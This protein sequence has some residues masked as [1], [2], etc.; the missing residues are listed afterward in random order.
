MT[1]ASSGAG[2]GGGRR[3]VAATGRLALWLWLVAPLVLGPVV[4]RAQECR[5][6][7]FLCLDESEC[8]PDSLRCDGTYDCPDLSDEL[9]CPLC[10]PGEWQCN[11]GT[12][13][14]GN[15]RC[16]FTRNC[17]YDDSDE[18]GC[19]GDC[20]PDQFRCGDGSCINGA[21]RCNGQQDCG[22]GSD[23]YNC[24][25]SCRFDEYR[26]RDGS[27]LPIHQR[28]DGDEQCS[29]GD[30]ELGCGICNR[31]QYQCRDGTCISFTKRCDRSPDCSDGSDEL[32][33]GSPDEAPCPS[34]DF[35]CYDLSCIP[36]SRMCDGRSDCPSG[37]DEQNCDCAANEFTCT[38]RM[39]IPDHLRCNYHQDCEDGSDEK[40]CP[41]EGCRQD[42]FTC[43][44]GECITNQYRCDGSYDCTDDSDELN[45]PST[46][47]PAPST[48]SPLEFEC[49]RGRCLSSSFRC[50]RVFD[51][52]DMSDEQGCEGQCL[53][54]QFRCNDSSCIPESRRCDNYR[55]CSDDELNCGPPTCS[56]QQF[57]CSDGFCISNVQRCDD[58]IDCPDASDEAGCGCRPDEFECN[59][60]SCVPQSLRCDSHYDCSD[61]SD[62]QKC[63]PS[64]PAP[65][66][67]RSN[68]FRCVR[69][70]ECIS[71][72]L[73]CN[74][75][76]DC[77]DYSD[78]EN[79]DSRD[80]LNLKTYPDEQIIK[81][82][83]EVVFQCRDE[84]PRRA[85][86]HWVRGNG[87]PL[88][89][90]SRDFNG[91]L[92]MP[93]IQ[94][95]HSGTYI[96]EALGVP[97][98]TPGRQ[99]SVHLT[100]EPFTLPQPRPPEACAI[101]EATCSNG[102]CISKTLVCDGNF[103]CSDGSDE[104]RCSAGGCEPNEFRCS[105]KKCVLKTWRCDGDDD[106]GDRSD[107]ENCATNPP[108]SPCRYNEFQCRRG[109]QCIPRAFHCDHQNDCQDGSDEY[110]CSSVHIQSPP[111]PMVVLDQGSVFT[112]TCK[113][114]GV[115]TPEVVWRLN[116]GH[117]P[118]KCRME[119]VGGE[120]KLTCPD[121][122]P[123]DQGAYSCEAINTRGSEFAVPDTILVVKR[124]SSVCQRGYFNDLA[125]TERDCIPCFCFG[126]TTECKS[127]DL[128]TYQ[129][130]PPITEYRLVTV[131]LNPDG[132]VNVRPSPPFRTS[133]IRSV[134][135]TGFQIYHQS[136][137]ERLPDNEYLYFALPENYLGHHLK[138]Y[139]GFVKYTVRPEGRG[140]L[141]NIPDVILTG[142]GYTLVHYVDNIE[143]GRENNVS[144]RLF[145][146]Q[147]KK[148]TYSGRPGGD[149]PSSSSN[150][151]L[152]S[153]EE[154]MMALS[155]VDSILIRGQYVQGPYLDTIF[156]NIGMDSAGI[157]NTGQGQA[158]F[159][160]FCSCPA[161]YTGLSCEQCAPGFHRHQTGPWLGLCTREV[162]QCPSGQ[163]G[164]PSRGVPCT[165]CPCPGTS[166][167]NQY[168]RTCQLGGDGDVICNCP[169]GYSGRR[170]ERC[171]VGYEGNPIASQ[172]CRPAAEC[173]PAGSL[174]PRPDSSGR[175]RCKE[176]TTGARCNQCT[177]NTF[178]LD[179]S[180]PDGCIAC[181]CMGVTGQCRSSNWYRQQI[182][183]T[184]TRGTNDF[185]LVES[186]KKDEPI[187]EGIQLNPE[188]RE[189]VF[190]DFSR[191]SPSV[192]YWK[193]PSQFLGDKITAYGGKLRYTLRYVPAPGGL[194]S[195]NNAPDVE[196]IST[197]DIHLMHFSREQISPERPQTIEVP[198]LEQYW[199]RQDGQ[200]TNREHLLMTL[201]DLEAIY[202]KA[203]YTTNTREAALSQ[204]SLDIAE[205]RN[206]GQ[207]RALEVEQCACP[208]GYR[209][210][211]CHDCD[212]GY[213][214][215]DGGLYLG[216]CEPCNCSGF[217]EDCDPETGVC[218]NCRDNTAGPQCESCAGGY[219]KQD[220]RCIYESSSQSLCRCDPRGIRQPG[221]PDGRSC[222][223]KTNVEGLQCDRCRRGTFDLSARHSEGCI[224]C[225]CSGVTDQCQSSRLQRTQIPMQLL[226][227][228]HG[229]TLVDSE[230]NSVVRSGFSE[231]VAENELG[232]DFRGRD[233]RLFW[234][235]PPQFT[236]NKLASYGGNLSVTQR[237]TARPGSQW[238]QDTDIL[239]FGNGIRIYWSGENTIQP[240]LPVTHVVPLVEREWRRLVS[241][242][243][244]QASRADLLTVLSDVEAI[245]IRA[246]PATQTLQTFVSDVSLDTAVEQ[247]TNQGRV[248]NI[249]ICR[250]PPGYRGTSCESCSVRYYRRVEPDGR[251]SCEKCP[252]ND[253]EESCSAAP[254]GEVICRCVPGFTGRYCD[255]P[256]GGV[257]PSPTEYPPP[258]PTITV[259]I[260]G[261][262][263]Q[264]VDA[265]GTVRFRCSGESVRRVPVKVSW[266]KESG[267]LPRGRAIDD[268]RGLLIITRV[269]PPDSGVYICSVDDGYEVAT[270]RATLNVGRPIPEPI[271][272]DVSP[273]VSTVSDGETAEFVCRS[274]GYPEPTLVWSRADGRPLG[275]RAYFSAGVLRIRAATPNDAGEF[276]C[277][278]WSPGGNTSRRAVLYVRER[279]GRPD[280]VPVVEPSEYSGPADQTVR[281]QC[282]GP[283]PDATLIWT[284]AGGAPLPPGARSQDGALLLYSPR[285]AHS[286]VY[287]CQSTRPGYPPT[288]AEAR[289]S[290]TAGPAPPPTS[291]RVEPERQTVPQGT[292]AEL[293][294]VAVGAPQS[295][296]SWTR[297]RES[298][299]P[300][301]APA[302]PILRIPNVA[303]HDRGVYVC[304]VSMPGRSP[305]QASSVLEVEPRERPSV[306]LYPGPQQTIVAGGS[307]LMQCRVT[308]GIPTPTVR[309]T[310]SDGRPLSPSITRLDGGVLRFEGV[311][312]AD[313]GQ[314]LC[315]AENPAGVATVTAELDVQE[316]PRISLTPPS[317]VSA[318][319]GQRVHLEC[320]A[321]GDPTPMLTW[322]RHKP[323]ES[324]YE[325]QA[326]TAEQLHAAVYEII[327]VTK[328]DEG[329]YSCRATN[330]AGSVEER[331]LL[332]VEE[333]NVIPGDPYRPE[334]PPSRPWNYP[335]GSGRPGRPGRPGSD[336]QGA[337][338]P[339]NGVS[340]SREVFTV[341]E[342]GNAEMRCLVKSPAPGANI[343]LTWT[344]RDGQPLSSH[345]YQRDGLLV[346]Q[347]VQK[348][349]E[350]EYS[351]LG[352][353]GDSVLFQATA[354]LEVIALP[355]IHLEPTRQVVQPGDNA[356]I[357]CSATGDQPIRLE[358]I[359][360]DR[361]F[362]SSVYVRDGLLQFRGIRVTDAGRYVCR[363][364]NREGKAESAAE[365]I[366]D[367]QTQQPFSS[368]RDQSVVAGQSIQLQCNV[369]SGVNALSYE[370]SR[371]RNLPLPSRAEERGGILVLRNVQPEDRGRYIC[372][373]NTPRGG[374]FT[375]YINL[376]VTQ[377]VWGG[378]H[379][380]GAIQCRRS[381]ECVPARSVCDGRPDCRDGSDEEECTT[382]RGRGL[383]NLVL[384]IDPS[385]EII[386]PGDH[387]DLRCVARGDAADVTYQ[388]SRV[389]GRL[390][391]NVLA[392]DDLLRIQDVKSENGGVYR[393]T[394][395]ADSGQYYEEYVLTL[396]GL[397][398]DTENAPAVET[399][400]APYGSTVTM[401]CKIDLEPPVTYG[402]SKQNGDLPPG[403]NTRGAILHLRDVSA[404]D[405]GT[406]VCSARNDLRQLDIPTVLVVTGIIPHFTQTPNSYMS[407]PTLA[408]AYT[409]FSI[410][411]S[412]KPEQPNG[413]ILYNGQHLNGSGDFI[414][415]G[416][417]D[418]YVEFRFNVGSGPAII[419]S[420]EPVMLGKWHTARLDRNRKLG[421]LEVDEQRIVTGKTQ[422]AFVGLD[423]EQPLYIGSVPDF[424]QINKLAGFQQGF[425]GCI[426]Q[427]V[428]GEKPIELIRQ[429]TSS[430]NMNVCDTCSGRPCHNNGVCQEAAEPQGYTCICPPGFGG[431]DC[432]RVGDACYPGVCNTG[433]CVNLDESF[434][435][436]CPM[437]KTG[438][439]CDEEISISQLRMGD[440]SYIAYPTPTRAMN[441]LS[442]EMRVKP[443]SLEDGLL[444]YCSQDEAGRGDFISLAVRDKHIEFRFD[445]GSGPAVMRSSRELV[446]GQWI[447]IMA[448]RH[449]RLGHLS[450]E[451][452][453]QVKA[454]SPGTTGG[455]NLRSLLFIGGVDPQRVRVAPG[456]NVS[457][458]FHGCISEVKVG[459]V[460]LDLLGGAVDAGNVKDC[461]ADTP[462]AAFSQDRQCR[463]QP[464]HNGG[465]CIAGSGTTY[466]C[467][468]PKG[469]SGK[470][471]ELKADMCQVLQPCRNGGTCEGSDSTYHCRC[472]IGFAGNDC[473]HNV[474]FTTEAGFRGDGY[475]ELKNSLLPHK[476]PDDQ[477]TIVIEFSTHEPNGLI[478]W[479]GQLPE[480]DG[481]GQDYLVLAVVNGTL[482][483]GYEL[484]S[485][486]ALITAP[487]RYVADG[488]RHRVV[489]KRQATDGN[490]ELDSEISEFGKSGGILQMLNTRGN[491]Y[492]GGTPKMERMTAGNYTY[493]FKGCIHSIEIQ[494]SGIL[495]L[496]E[497]AL[498]GVNVAPCSRSR[499]VPSSLVLMT[500]ESAGSEKGMP[501]VHTT[502][503]AASLS[504]SASLLSLCFSTI[505]LAY[506][507]L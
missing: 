196:L 31:D 499:W 19:R 420:H 411:V 374:R 432:D 152:A 483:F 141:L 192:L 129:L 472:P 310:R 431:R 295:A 170:C 253:N 55:D 183:S 65:S 452:E 38:N 410:T 284:R 94:L 288:T 144:A 249:E 242:G 123:Q 57:Q 72:S 130:P 186:Q 491:I 85:R 378:C 224:S 465:T 44:N 430:H 451:G 97:A 229:F 259:S 426:S 384:R 10:K 189:I 366:V 271:R 328:L 318:V 418:S 386:R 119:S 147:W 232:Y 404:R 36:L 121:I 298:L 155:N 108:G 377:N 195:R 2:A 450:V 23:E 210:L 296:I 275:P 221:C 12:C 289:V 453:P 162:Q 316:M 361:E 502:H 342:N 254:N 349:D 32:D 398:E 346:I 26:C 64:T 48:C 243:P 248:T 20:R 202:I 168:G 380:Q 128:F 494:D 327:R 225:W 441:Q 100:V 164:D 92:E 131:N 160:E 356:N 482:Q 263:I 153:R 244:R 136:G 201:A 22:D 104:M 365:V 445:T 352:Y 468:C 343:F 392:F 40:N 112:I 360:P 217:S 306:D 292:T 506:Q 463:Y 240:D 456:V 209:G 87:L 212:V 173:D 51:C 333:A 479:H 364:T 301:A 207:N 415:L 315:T 498:D 455:L 140:P 331:L 493:G 230:R 82:G 91:R 485:G 486:P 117:V 214:R 449:M 373:I 320:R 46:N 166:V 348:S 294:C 261:P 127:A 428:I 344:R 321:S 319:E 274:S 7:E 341:L 15:L 107:E 282:R 101:H 291:I 77:Q 260:L 78:E 200:P 387:L 345:S 376:T 267:E 437:N 401:D 89:P 466:S 250:C 258:P 190:S 79:C 199:Q 335:G 203:T 460:Q 103:D 424:N 469:F 435:C 390:A 299:P 110:G 481:R 54:G 71:S 385:H 17:P 257:A 403:V 8:L 503:G 181:F 157:T 457:T 30:D 86:V 42:E 50:N 182:S 436:Y 39:C 256:D 281:L 355:A 324:F 139:G 35:S 438:E 45:C 427:L 124:P 314:Y 74:K 194:S 90:G 434:L 336:S 241:A 323:G 389:G 222:V 283:S 407:L 358:W 109:N 70:G 25:T 397:S 63:E 75:R 369:P 268:G 383:Q 278:A 177:N 454:L 135:R 220:G 154:I 118:A 325:P 185:H 293:R 37:E 88:P 399:R 416:L 351:C 180:N 218:T 375:N 233:Q 6:G 371:P 280:Q 495:N 478:F 504:T 394:V 174:Q 276:L 332:T 354:R 448:R 43:A 362:P 497:E 475:L 58:Q 340:I 425:V 402:W 413:L 213:T 313:E 372:I 83:R 56:S 29:D 126:I 330:A 311:T 5:P 76:F 353:E 125:T 198:L 367:S 9:D 322:S 400:S 350:G 84:G 134:S 255:N 251:F 279:L 382:R 211:S 461:S 458:G 412:F 21:A 419:R 245:L 18:D 326:V 406:Y 309:W 99:V 156:S 68:E 421:T 470:T 501:V 111:P 197:N 473:E 368:A 161:G 236:G 69:S 505:L 334:R 60:G 151:D 227:G 226:S 302:G 158:S 357:T 444:A 188:Q 138:S 443:E 148:H 273:P 266:S 80:G 300:G 442:F 175:C 228:T 163:F 476:N 34:T 238:Q 95:D 27:C 417:N 270:Q 96:C 132:Q 462:T 14:D 285:P 146:G 137:Y 176:Y 150:E 467:I 439:R 317:P 246:K 239:I 303:V 297:A 179:A 105:N 287:V 488:Q 206:T 102:E 219:T 16:D 187:R 208:Q 47:P 308:G 338:E 359:T 205:E 28:C 11:D 24:N 487:Q 171:D 216:T 1:R 133:P 429:A 52:A 178:H 391:D 231:N 235:L 409:T 61:G 484:G 62:E 393:C 247:T 381:L 347:R 396:Q 459:G 3:K 53:P 41:D 191:R 447:T 477:E 312:L 474:P 507:A 98:S 480:T 33:C 4:V 265:G 388:W 204:V 106:C 433:R 414:S 116:W 492:I 464:C 500:G 408:N 172:P 304:S 339:G 363:A 122:Q 67:C 489:L 237:Y 264:I 405:A 269:E 277:H 184:F 262:A 49:D 142:N 252:C 490:L 165:D 13:I 234:S 272:L 113:A 159:V 423:L 286:G 471:C 81:E 290:I 305:A 145:Y 73:V 379:E 215:T 337:G 120:G 446:P 329:S 223:C 169:P 422:G 167:S 114:L 395:T 193:L 440:N 59:D 143:L 307:V 370:W 66:P 93:E 496:R 115:P 149:I